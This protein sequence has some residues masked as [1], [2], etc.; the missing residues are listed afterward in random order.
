[1]SD[2]KTT[3]AEIP[4]D[5]KLTQHRLNKLLEI[6][7]NHGIL[8]QGPIPAEIVQRLESMGWLD[9]P[10][11]FKEPFGGDSANCI[12]SIS[13]GDSDDLEG[14]EPD[15]EVTVNMAFPRTWEQVIE[16]KSR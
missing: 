9:E 15:I 14:F 6:Y 12:T 1:M 8:I 7:H 16:E 3:I 4:K 10:L 5:F 2:T 13:V 11:I